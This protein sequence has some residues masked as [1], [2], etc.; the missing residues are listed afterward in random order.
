M[1]NIKI[2]ILQLIRINNSDKDFVLYDLN[3]DNRVTC[4][5]FTND[6]SRY[7]NKY[8]YFKLTDLLKNKSKNL[9][10]NL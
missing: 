5:K 3:N 9:T 1:H 2:D 4:I 6:L 10:I 7:R 8:Q